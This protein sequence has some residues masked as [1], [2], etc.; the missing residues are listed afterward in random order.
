MSNKPPVNID[1]SNEAKKAKRKAKSVE[2][3]LGIPKA[4][5]TRKGG[6]RRKQKCVVFRSTLAAAALSVSTEWINNRNRI[7]LNESQAVR[8]P[9]KIMGTGYFGNDEEVISSIMVT[10]GE[11]LLRATLAVHQ[12]A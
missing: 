10:D 1:P 5:G 12:T 4:T 9:T 2:D 3:I 6:R 7:L 8:T 11:E